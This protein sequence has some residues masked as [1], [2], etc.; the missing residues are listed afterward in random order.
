[1]ADYD[2]FVVGLVL[3][4]NDVANKDK[5]K[6]L[7]VDVGASEPLNIVT[8][9]PNIKEGVRVVVAKEGA[10]VTCD[11]NEIVVAKATVGGCKSEGM[12]CDA[13]MLGWSGGGA[14]AA[15]LVPDTF[16]V[17][18]QPPPSR[19]R[20]DGKGAETA[21]ADDKPIDT[22]FERKLTKEEKKAAAKAK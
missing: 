17:G 1:M 13:P 4:L 9:A 12:L 22:L 14:G 3:A 2:G 6:E 10:T 19:P 15:A 20:M 21:P 16:E 11:G 18:S 8:N 5:L 7:Q